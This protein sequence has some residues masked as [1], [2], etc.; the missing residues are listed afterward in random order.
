MY[1]CRTIANA[2]IEPAVTQLLGCDTDDPNI[3]LLRTPT[4]F[5]EEWLHPV[6]PQL[7]SLL[8]P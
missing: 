1:F 3:P 2:N 6:L 4:S 5:K 7:R 8:S